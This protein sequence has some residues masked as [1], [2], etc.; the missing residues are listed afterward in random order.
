MKKRQQQTTKGLENTRRRVLRLAQ[1]SIRTLGSDDLSQ[2]ISGC[3][4]TSFTTEK[5]AAGG[6][7]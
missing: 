3:D 4:T 5:P 1:E 6:G 2:A 7:L